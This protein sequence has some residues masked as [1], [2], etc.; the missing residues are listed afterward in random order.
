MAYE[1]RQWISH[2]LLNYNNQ[3]KSFDL[4][5]LLWKDYIYNM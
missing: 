3:M 5:S 4:V 2:I 1:M